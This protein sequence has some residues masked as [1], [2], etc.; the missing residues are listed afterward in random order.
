MA[1]PDK[2][3]DGKD[4]EFMDQLE[5]A[6]RMKPHKAS[7]IMLWSIT[8][9]I[10]FFLLWASLAQVEEITRGQGQVV[11]TKD[12]QTVQSLEGGILQE[13]LVEQGDKVT[14]G[15]VL[16]RLSDVMFSSEE[17]GA[18]AKSGSLKLKIARLEAE[19]SGQEF[20]IPEDLLKKSPDIAQNELALYRSRQQ[21]LKNAISILE[22][23]LRTVTADIDEAQAQISRLSSSRGSLQQEL[24]ITRDMVAKKAVSKLEQ[25]RLEREVNDI[26]GQIQAQQERIGGLRA[27]L[28]ATEKQKND[29]MDRFRSQAL[30]EL[31]DVKT[32][33]ALLGENLKS[34]GDRVNRAELRAPVDG[35]VNNIAV[36][37][38][39]GV[40]E[41]AQKLIEIV[42]IDSELKIIA[43]VS[44][45]NI[46]FLRVGQN[47][48]VKISAYNP[49]RYGSLSGKLTRIGASSVTDRE[50]NVFFEIEVRTD[51]NHLGTEDA[52]LP[53]TPGMVADAEIITGK[54]TIMEYILKPFLQARDRALRE[55]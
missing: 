13:L 52:P 2:E 46:A 31:S 7:N 42:P 35:V 44:P 45:N 12:I 19:A 51:K 16:L 26:G 53:V 47:A 9:M 22:D 4:I 38:V 40:V 8:G 6:S 48:K 37:T 23:K 32:Q 24:T 21:E 25:I 18:E 39:G 30:T 54:R 28:S 11:P 34:I 15:Q 36:R 1:R 14:K 43:K 55:P 50:G 20:I 49:Q 5:A 27:D 29:Q 17:R 3:S 41:P 33:S 10:A